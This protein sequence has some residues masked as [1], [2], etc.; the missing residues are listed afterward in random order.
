MF[1]TKSIVR[2]IRNCRKISNR[3]V[4]NDKKISASNDMINY[5]IIGEFNDEFVV[6]I[7]MLLSSMP[8]DG[9]VQLR[10]KRNQLFIETM[11]SSFNIPKCN[12]VL[13]NGRKKS[14]RKISFDL[15]IDLV[16]QIIYKKKYNE[17]YSNLNIVGEPDKRIQVFIENDLSGARYGF[18]TNIQSDEFFH[19][20]LDKNMLPISRDETGLLRCNVFVDS[21]VSFYWKNNFAHRFELRDSLC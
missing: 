8:R 20:T 6:D 7:D 4:V 14:P 2:S 17:E 12:E 21:S 11:T 15:P 9:I 5:E 16:S 3:L 18:V 13:I 19:I 10:T 1:L